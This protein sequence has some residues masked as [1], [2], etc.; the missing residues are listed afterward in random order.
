MITEEQKEKYLKHG[1]THCPYCDGQ[2]FE[3]G[4]VQLDAGCAW[5]ELFC[6]D[7]EKEWADIYS[8]TDVEEK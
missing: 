8:L 3:G 4:Q 6:N 1:G 7:C 2:D 5:Q